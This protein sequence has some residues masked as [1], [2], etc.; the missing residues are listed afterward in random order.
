M[1]YKITYKRCQGGI[2]EAQVLEKKVTAKNLEEGLYKLA[3][4]ENTSLWYI[5][6]INVVI[7]EYGVTNSPADFGYLKFQELP[8]F[9]LLGNH[10]YKFDPPYHSLYVQYP[11]AEAPSKLTILPLQPKLKLTH[12]SDNTTRS[13]I[14]TNKPVIVP[15]APKKKYKHVATL[16]S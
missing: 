6:V 13:R 7:D 5:Y 12:K 8:I 3:Y 9:S 16:P 2:R 10:K 15:E 1:V 14:I 4:L 11:Y